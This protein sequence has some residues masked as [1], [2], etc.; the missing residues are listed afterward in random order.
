MRDELQVMRNELQV[1]RL[2]RAFESLEGLSCGDA[3]GERFVV[4]RDIAQSLIKDRAAPAPPWF[5][6]DD[7]MM[8]LSIV[9][10]LKEY[11]EINQE[12][13]VRSFARHYDPE[14]GY[15]AGMHGLLSKIRNRIDSWEKESRA[16]FG[17][18]GSFGN[19]SAMRVAPVGAYFADDLD[20]IVEQATLSS[21]TTHCHKEAIAG[22]VAVAVAAGL[23]CQ[24]KQRRLSAGSAELLE[25]IALRTPSG[26]VRRGIQKA[27]DLPVDCSVEQAAAALG[28]GSAV[29]APDTVPF[30]LWAATRHLNS[31]ED[32]LWTT[33]SAF[34][35]SDTNCAIVGG[36]V[37]LYAGRESIP[38]KWIE[39]RETLPLH[40]FNRMSTSSVD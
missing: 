40:L 34:G 16:L 26:Y 4:P 29:T 33:V 20:K 1:V 12:S 35:D 21:I 13:L 31:Y 36:I 37:V 3:F 30:A 15:G 24:C 39:S 17:G 25:E 27:K 11:G 28:N 8:A 7:T 6:T 19:G 10:I 5:F 2:K 9:S 22:A 23:A 32:A 38:A 18:E 14:R